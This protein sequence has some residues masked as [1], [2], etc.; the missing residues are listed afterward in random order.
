[1]SPAGSQSGI[2]INRDDGLN[3]PVSP[4]YHCKESKDSKELDVCVHREESLKVLPVSNASTSFSKSIKSMVSKMGATMNDNLDEKSRKKISVTCH[5]TETVQRTPDPDEIE[6]RSTNIS[7]VLVGPEVL[8]PPLAK[9]P[10]QKM[11]EIT[12]SSIQGENSFNSFLSEP[13]PFYFK[14]TH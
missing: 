7:K 8:I 1:M 5:A 2:H 10:P 3:S 4:E 9:R 14:Y 11:I 13:N 12:S 6:S